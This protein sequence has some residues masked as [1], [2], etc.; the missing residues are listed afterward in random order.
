MSRE[1]WERAAE[2]PEAFVRGHGLTLGVE[3]DVIQ[4]GAGQMA[5]LLHRTGTTSPPWTGFLAVDRSQS[6]VIGMCGFKA[7]PDSEGLVE[8]AYGTFPKFE[9]R[10]VATS[11]ATLLVERARQ[12][13]SVRRVIAHTLPETN[14]STRVLEKNGF[15]HTGPVIDPEDG[16]VWR[17]E[18]ALSRRQN[19]AIT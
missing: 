8:I 10:G 1:D 3:S 16:L 18:L 4:S 9:G 2:D 12:E 13:T 11:M 17:W 14:A 6:L 7:P 15:A 5:S 19:D